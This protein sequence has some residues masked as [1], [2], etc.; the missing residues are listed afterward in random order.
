[1]SIAA[2]MNTIIATALSLGINRQRFT[3]D[4]QV[5]L[6]LSISIFRWVT[7]LG[8]ARFERL[9]RELRLLFLALRLV[10]PV[11]VSALLAFAFW[12]TLTRLAFLAASTLVFIARV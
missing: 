9:H 2:A 4:D 5:S 12:F 1:M 3:R 7:A 8:M 11:L 10:A 6:R